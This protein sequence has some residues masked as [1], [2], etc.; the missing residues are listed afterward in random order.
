MKLFIS[1]FCIIFLTQNSFA[2]NFTFFLNILKMSSASKLMSSFCYIPRAIAL[3][4]GIV[5]FDFQVTHGLPDGGVNVAKPRGILIPG[6]LIYRHLLDLLDRLERPLKK[7]SSEQKILGHCHEILRSRVVYPFKPVR[8]RFNSTSLYLP[9]S[10]LLIELINPTFNCVFEFL[11][12]GKRVQ[13]VQTLAELIAGLVRIQ[14]EVI[15]FRSGRCHHL[16]VFG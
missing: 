14:P 9:F 7:L 5:G 10:L 3:L 15:R 1:F 2:Q 13:H 16:T 11:V 4:H 6:K 12:R 8:F